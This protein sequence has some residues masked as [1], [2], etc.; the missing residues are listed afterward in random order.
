M[1]IFFYMY[2]QICI[3]VC[4]CLCLSV[5]VFMFGYVRVYVRVFVGFVF[6]FTYVCRF[7]VIGVCMF[8]SLCMFI[9]VYNMCICVFFVFR[10]FLGFI[11]LQEFI[12]VFSR[13]NIRLKIR[14]F[15]FD[16][17]DSR[18]LFKEMKR[19]REFRIIFDCSYVMVVQIF[20][21]VRE[22]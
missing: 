6:M 7:V 14:Q 4:I 3:V 17:D 16:F 9:V 5:L 20:K 10:C 8:M 2:V 1:G 13:Y 15:F 22:R 19:G 18:F 12:M 11:R 21:Q